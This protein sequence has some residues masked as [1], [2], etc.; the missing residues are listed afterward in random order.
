MPEYNREDIIR[1][2]DSAGSIRDKYAMISRETGGD[3]NI[4]QIADI[5]TKE[6]AVCRVLAELLSPKG[7]HG[8]GGA[9]L[10]LFLRD[11]LKERGFTKDEIARAVV[12]REH[13]AYGRRIDLVIEVGSR[14]IPIEA[15]IYA[16]DQW[17]QCEDYYQYA[18]DKFGD[19]AKVVYLTLGGNAPSEDS[20]GELDLKSIVLLSFERDI[21]QW[22]EKCL[23]L[24]DTIRKAPVRE[25]IQQF[26]SAMKYMT[27]QLED[28]AMDEM[29]ELLFGSEQ[30]MSNT[31]IMASAIDAS[32]KK[33]VEMTRKFFDAFHARLHGDYERYITASDYD[34]QMDDHPSINYKIAD[35]EKGESLLFTMETYKGEYLCAG[36][37]FAKNGEHFSNKE[38]SD[39][40]RKR[41]DDIDGLK[42][43]EWW[44]FWDAIVFDDESVYL[45]NP[46]GNYINYFRLFNPETFERIVDETVDQARFLIA[47]L[48]RS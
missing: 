24:P 32:K 46:R 4:F 44:V 35:L 26:I 37:T 18:K 31:L 41:F 22:L 12:S 33:S 42:G 21:V 15:K 20:L 19:A 14:L 47:K 30:N 10:E 3:F 39:D 28:K 11:C 8:Q 25:I 40:L 6:V 48:K 1:L 17:R 45:L 27:N 2:L 16:G 29:M 23:Q 9:Y 13:P 38:T 36:F 34:K 43:N 7:S 5:S